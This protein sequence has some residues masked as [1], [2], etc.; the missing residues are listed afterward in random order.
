MAAPDGKGTVFYRLLET[1]SFL[2]TTSTPEEV[3]TAARKALAAIPPYETADGKEKD[4]L[5]GRPK[6]AHFKAVHLQLGDCG[7]AADCGKA[8]AATLDPPGYLPLRNAVVRYS[9]NRLDDSQLEVTLAKDVEQRFTKYLKFDWTKKYL[10]VKRVELSDGSWALETDTGMRTTIHELVKSSQVFTRCLRFFRAEH[11]W[12]KGAEHD[13]VD[14]SI[15]TLRFTALALLGLAPQQKVAGVVSGLPDTG[16]S[17]LFEVLT[18]CFGDDFE[19]SSG[20]RSSDATKTTINYA[21]RYAMTTHRLVKLKEEQGFNF[22]AVRE[23]LG[24]NDV[25]VKRNPNDTRGEKRGVT[26]TLLVEVN[27]PSKVTLGSSLSGLAEKV[28]AVHLAPLDSD[29]VS[30]GGDEPAR[31]EFTKRI[32]E[33]IFFLQLL[34][35]V[36]IP[37]AERAIADFWRQKKPLPDSKWRPP[38]LVE[39]QEAARAAGGAAAACPSLSDRVRGF[40]EENFEKTVWPRLDELLTKDAF[41]KIAHLQKLMV[42]NGIVGIGASAVIQMLRETGFDVR[43]FNRYV[44]DADGSIRK[45]HVKNAVLVRRLIAD[46]TEAA[47]A[48][49]VDCALW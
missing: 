45:R 4:K 26:A 3:E 37:E 20:L 9:S 17:T 31:K 18:S 16:K 19:G 12:S 34:A 28:L 39:V 30:I 43:E 6:L 14:F 24:G 33:E 5:L 11:G 29:F 41:I 23:M 21:I 48:T 38:L 42:D 32:A 47:H 10:K 7:L 15:Q 36:S 13:P 49:R 25:M 44:E 35:L 2:W 40:M 8:F 22:E 46:D 1:G 27:D